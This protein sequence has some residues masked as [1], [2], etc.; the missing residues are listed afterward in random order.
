MTATALGQ[1]I[2]WAALTATGRPHSA[3]RC[4]LFPAHRRVQPAAAKAL[5]T[6]APAEPFPGSSRIVPTLRRFHDEPGFCPAAVVIDSNPTR[7][8]QIA[9]FLDQPL[10]RL[11]A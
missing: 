2:N 6:L 1:V 10:I 5:V 4:A 7:G 3:G 11:R 8:S 9:G